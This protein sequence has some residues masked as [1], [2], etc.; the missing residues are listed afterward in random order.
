LLEFGRSEE[1]VLQV[2]LASWCHWD[3]RGSVPN[4]LGAESH[5]DEF[6]AACE[7]VWQQNRLVVERG[8]VAKIAA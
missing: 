7:E 6:R 1:G 5:T 2:S 3:E 4:K 8:V